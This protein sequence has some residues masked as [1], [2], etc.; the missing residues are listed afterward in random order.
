MTLVLFVKELLV[1][2]VNQVHK[3][4]LDHMVKEVKMVH[5]D[6]LDHQENQDHRVLEESLDS[7]GKMVLMVK[8]VLLVK[9]DFLENAVQRVQWVCSVPQVFQVM[10]V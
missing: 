6:Q 4:H 9:M 5:K 1:Q 7:L 2:S 8:K 3:D 10:L